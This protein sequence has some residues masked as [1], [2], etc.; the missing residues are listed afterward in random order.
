MTRFRVLW[1]APVLLAL[2]APAHAQETA[3]GISVTP[4]AYFMG[5]GGAASNLEFENFSPAIAAEYGER[6]HRH[7]YAYANLRYVDNLMGDAMRTNLETASQDLGLDFSGRDRALTFTVGAKFFLPNDSRFRPYFGAGL[8]LLNLKRRIQ[9]RTLGDVS[10]AFYGLTGLNDGVV[11]AG[12]TA[13][14]TAMGE[15]MLG[16]SGA[17]SNRTYL[18]V[19]Y[20]YGSSFHSTDR[21]DFG[22]A[23]FGIGVAF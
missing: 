4:R 7:V 5:V 12:R 1:I 8:G 18:D 21:V 2:G 23:T 13:S 20:R 3:T 9:E 22:Q 10:D 11:D 19:A 14:T 15:V 16:F 17:L 6:V